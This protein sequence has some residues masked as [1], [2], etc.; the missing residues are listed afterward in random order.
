[1]PGGKGNIKPSDG[2]QFSKEYQ[3]KEKWTEERAL[4]EVGHPL[5]EWLLAKD[6]DGNDKGN[7]FFEEFLIIENN[8]YHDLVRYL[9]EKFTSFSEL[10]ERARKI[11]ELKLQKYGVADRLNA[12]MT[13]FVLINKHNWKDK[14][15]HENTN[16]NYNSAD[17]TPDEI[18]KIDAA[19]ENEV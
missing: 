17:M 14:I 19:L 10:I 6:K 1:M 3:P 12:T 5:I 15:E 18:K 2:K 9:S 4:N 8:Y 13:K 16:Y 11:Q 7:M